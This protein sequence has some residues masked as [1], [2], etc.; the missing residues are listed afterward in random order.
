MVCG[1]VRRSAYSIAVRR[2]FSPLIGSGRSLVVLTTRL[3]FWVL[4]SEKPT[5]RIPGADAVTVYWPG[6]AAAEAVTAALPPAMMAV[7]VGRKA[8]APADGAAKAMTPP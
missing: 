4:V 2:L 1:P 7:V 8:E 5:L 3:G 6:A